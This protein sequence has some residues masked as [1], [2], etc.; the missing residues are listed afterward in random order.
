MQDPI[1]VLSLAVR[2]QCRRQDISGGGGHFKGAPIKDVSIM[3]LLPNL[4]NCV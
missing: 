2:R 4:F 3:Q 1:D